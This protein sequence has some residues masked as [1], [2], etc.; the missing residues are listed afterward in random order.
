MVGLFF[1]RGTRIRT[2]DP[3]LPKQVR[4]RAALRPEFLFA[5]TKFAEEAGFEPAVQ[6][7]PV[8]RFSKPVVSATHPF[9]R[10]GRKDKAGFFLSKHQYNF[11]LKKLVPAL[12]EYFL[13]KFAAF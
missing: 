2:W 3:L 12:F 9:L 10:M 11:F 6:V 13:H 5:E 4:Y 7:I 8:R 1:C